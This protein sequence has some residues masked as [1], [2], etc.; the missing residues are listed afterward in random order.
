MAANLEQHAIMHRMSR[1]HLTDFVV[2][3]KRF[4][5]QANFPN[6]LTP[7]I[8]CI[9]GRSTKSGYTFAHSYGDRVDLP[10]CCGPQAGP[11]RAPHTT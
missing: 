6:P 5:L 4:Y 1:D 3:P 7:A 10:L 11:A 8:G 9:H 2:H